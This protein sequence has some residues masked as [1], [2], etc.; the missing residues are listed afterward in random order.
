V[1]D[2]CATRQTV[3]LGGS[4]QELRC[5]VQL[6]SNKQLIVC[7]DHLE[8]NTLSC[9]HPQQD[10]AAWHLWC[11]GDQRLFRIGDDNALIGY[12]FEAELFDRKPID[13][14]RHANSLLVRF[15]QC[16]LRTR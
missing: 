5:R 9:W 7:T 8:R 1:F 16:E 11:T 4:R 12:A 15:K 3:E 10:A 6:V 14:Q 13:S 2:Q